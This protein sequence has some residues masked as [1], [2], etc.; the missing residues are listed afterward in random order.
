[1]EENLPVVD[2]GAG[3]PATPQATYH[4]PTGAIQWL[5]D[6]QFAPPTE[7]QPPKIIASIDGN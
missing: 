3:G 2:Y 6:V 5:T 4:C 1:M 7:P